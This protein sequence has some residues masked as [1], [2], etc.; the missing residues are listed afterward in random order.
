MS[1]LYEHKSSRTFAVPI[2]VGE[3]PSSLSEAKNTNGANEIMLED[4]SEVASPRKLTS[5]VVIIKTILP[6]SNHLII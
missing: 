4:T 2:N 1:F 5:D 3:E 6:F